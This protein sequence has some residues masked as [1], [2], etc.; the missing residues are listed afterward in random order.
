MELCLGISPIPHFYLDLAGNALRA[1]TC[2]YSISRLT[3]GVTS[4]LSGFNDFTMNIRAI[5]YSGLYLPS[6][7]P[8]ALNSVTRA[9]V[10]L[11]DPENT[12]HMIS[13]YPCST[14]RALDEA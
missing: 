9:Q 4:I 13:T 8:H 6:S 1:Y 11:T 5:N 2:G 3:S 14:V 12:E 10:T 7:L